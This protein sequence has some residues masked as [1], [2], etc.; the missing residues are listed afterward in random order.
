MYKDGLLKDEEIYSNLDAIV[1][2]QKPGRENDDEFIY[3]CSVG[4]AFIDVSFAKYVY[5]KAIDKKIGT[6]YEF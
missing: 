2:G 4:L 3:F 6:W 5:E 1:T